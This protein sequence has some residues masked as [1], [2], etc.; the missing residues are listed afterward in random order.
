MCWHQNY[1]QKRGKHNLYCP[2][3]ISCR[4]ILAEIISCVKIV[5]ALYKRSHSHTHMP[6]SAQVIVTN[7]NLGPNQ[8]IKNN[9]TQK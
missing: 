5:M 4:F 3:S 7:S 9:V 6:K 8:F 1:K 2:V